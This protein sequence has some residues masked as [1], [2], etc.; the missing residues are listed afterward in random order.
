MPLQ[1]AGVRA[2]ASSA[3]VSL[4]P[5]SVDG[6]GAA[7][8]IVPLPADLGA[9]SKDELIQHLMVFQSMSERTSKQVED[10]RKRRRAD[11]QT[12]R[13]LKARR[14]EL[15]KLN[16]AQSTRPS[17]EITSRVAEKTGHKKDGK[18]L[19]VQGGFA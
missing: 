9:L 11:Q 5:A 15:V 7:S 1:D 18:Y 16:D 10:L 17:L 6:H 12:V 14:D 13:R 8:Q 2:V 19:S 4:P 3:I